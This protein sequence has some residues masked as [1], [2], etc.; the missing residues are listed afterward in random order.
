[1]ALV[2]EVKNLRSSVSRSA[3]FTLGDLFS[4]AKKQIEQDMDII[5]QALLHKCGE[6][7][8]FIR[9]DID[10]AISNMIEEMPQSKSA[11]ALILNG[12]NHRVLYVRRTTAQYMCILVEKMGA[13]KCLMGG[14]R[15]IAEPMLPALARFVQDGS[16]HT[17]YYGRKMFSI[18]MGH[19][20]F[21]KLLRKYV[22]PGTYRNI[23]GILESIKRRGIGDKPPD[24]QSK[25]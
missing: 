5:C 24:L 11:L 3:I 13:N 7:V 2:Y 9:E 10:K 6:N 22:T 1:L 25:V 14:P 4:K 21:E 20:S 19:N 16:P 17:R 18:L 8:A 15:D 12:A 23:H